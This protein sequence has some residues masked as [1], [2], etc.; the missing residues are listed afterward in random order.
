MHIS[1]PLLCF[2]PSHFPFPLPSPAAEWLQAEAKHICH[3]IALEK[4][5]TERQ[6]EAV[7]LRQEVASL[8]R[9]LEMLEKERKDVLVRLAD[10]TKCH[11]LA[12]FGPCVHSSKEHLFPV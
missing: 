3:Q 9:K 10:A 8:K 1:L 12:M 2:F 4:E 7:A 11:F 5:A 6:E